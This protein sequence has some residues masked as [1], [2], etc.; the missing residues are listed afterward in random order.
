VIVVPAVDI[1]HGR[2]VRLRQ[3][4]VGD[5][6]V[7]G[8]DP[9]VAGRRWESEGAKRVHIVDLDAAIDGKP[10]PEAIGA[11]IG[12]LRIPVEV[13]GGL[14]TVGDARRYLDEH[15][16]DRVIFGTAAVAHREIVQ[17]AVALWPEA[18][19]VAI[20]ARDG[21][22]AVEG[23]TQTTAVD[24]LE[25]AAEAEGWGVSRVQYTDIARDGTLVGPNLAAIARLG[26]GTGLRISAAGG[27]STL[28][29]LRRL[30]S[31]GLSGLDEVIVGRAL[32]DGCFTLAEAMAALG[33]EGGE[34]T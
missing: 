4:E 30:A 24:A 9:V 5:E 18:V 34:R 14:R 27:I 33:S 13:G 2:V 3:G 17:E 15:G 23:W 16:A 6:T 32:Y 10:Q 25:L 8:T 19:V 7:Y 26:R 1:R 21:R 11:V 31:L 20:D 28:D 12:A 29:D 22:T